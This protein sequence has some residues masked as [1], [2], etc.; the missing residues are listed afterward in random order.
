MRFL[1]PSLYSLTEKHAA[2]R[3][4]RSVSTIKRRRIYRLRF[5]GKTRKYPAGAI[6]LQISRNIRYRSKNTWYFAEKPANANIDYKYGD[7]LKWK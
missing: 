4:L 2:E 6:I 7:G 1:K 5:F 3:N